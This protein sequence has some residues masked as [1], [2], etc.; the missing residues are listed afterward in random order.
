MDFL[1]ISNKKINH[2]INNKM[3]LLL[4]GCGITCQ[5]INIVRHRVFFLGGGGNDRNRCNRSE[6][7]ETFYC[8]YIYCSLYYLQRINVNMAHDDTKMTITISHD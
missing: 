6:Q 2:K 4:F 3:F 1:T 7:N 5:S 8:L